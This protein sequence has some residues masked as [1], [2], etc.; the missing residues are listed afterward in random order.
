MVPHARRYLGKENIAR[1]MAAFHEAHPTVALELRVTRHPFSFISDYDGDALDRMTLKREGTWKDRLL[2]YTGGN[3]HA[4][5]AAMA[6]MKQAGCAVGIDFDYS[7]YINRQPVDSQRM[8]LYAARQGKQEA[9]VTALSK[10]HFTQGHKGESASTRP[11]VLAAAEEAGIGRV[12]AAAFYDSDE[13]RD[14]VWRS[15]GEMP[16]KGISAIPLFVFNVPEIGLEGGPL[17]PDARGTTPP[18]VNGSMQIP[19]FVDIFTQLWAAVEQSRRALG[20]GGALLAPP[21]APPPAPA[22]ASLAAGPLTGKR[23]VLRGLV[24]KP[25]LNGTA[26]VCGRYDAAKGR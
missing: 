4:R 21:P 23:V 25:H 2:D 18:I 26:G 15:Y 20:G 14:V 16:K 5:D 7:C 11:T 12:E 3:E 22:A 19:L 17:R 8:L 9:Y 13:L 6:G 24:G 10:R 1:A